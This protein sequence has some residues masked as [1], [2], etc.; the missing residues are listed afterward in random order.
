MTAFTRDITQAYIQSHHDLERKVFI[1]TPTYMDLP[2]N[3]VLQVV[4]PL[5]AITEGVF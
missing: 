2:E 1:R 3:V 4:K 5:Y